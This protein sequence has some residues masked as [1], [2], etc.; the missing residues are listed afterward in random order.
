MRAALALNGLNS[1]SLHLTGIN[2]AGPF[3]FSLMPRSSRVFVVQQFGEVN[4]DNTSGRTDK[5]INL[6]P[7]GNIEFLRSSNNSTLSVEIVEGSI[8]LFRFVRS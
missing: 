5:S 1:Q 8:K 3:F 2:L 6:N 4:K 7:V